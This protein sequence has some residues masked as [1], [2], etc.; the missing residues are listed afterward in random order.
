MQLLRTELYKIFSKPRTYI[1]F[2]TIT[3]IALLIQIALKANGQEFLDFFLQGVNGVFTISGNMLNGYFVTYVILGLL[4][5]HVPLLVSLVAGDLIAGEASAGTLRLLLT[6][7]ISRTR[8]ILT[9]FLASVIYSFGLVVW[10][11][12]CALLLSIL[13]F[14]V[15]D[16]PI[17]KADQFIILLRDDVLW[18]YGC[19]FLF[20]VLAMATVSA[21]A[22]FL[23]AFSGNAIGP[24]VGTMGVIIVLTII[25]NLDVPLFN[26][27]KPGLFT[28]HM[29]GWKGFFY[30]PVP[31]AAIG[32]SALV[33]AGYIIAFVGATV[34]YFNKKDIQS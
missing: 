16:M 5:V 20:A 22:L 21:L 2:G 23:S 13:L 4:L 7:P 17:A 11:A 14:G 12:I 8:I 32:K 28:T 6:K 30:S 9:K 1:A 34:F 3:V 25:T 26:V 15:S 27:I 18:R 29:L 10:L 31:Y 33:L 19:A 24:V